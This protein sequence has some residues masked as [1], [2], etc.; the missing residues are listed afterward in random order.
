VSK[1]LTFAVEKEKK[2]KRKREK[3]KRGQST[4]LD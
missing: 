1:H 4:Y 2:E 3:R